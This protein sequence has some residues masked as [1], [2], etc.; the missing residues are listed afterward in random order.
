MT[1]A[2]GNNP[3]KQMMGAATARYRDAGRSTFGKPIPS[4]N[5]YSAGA[6]SPFNL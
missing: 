4:T 3:A 6:S 1:R 5:C 2:A